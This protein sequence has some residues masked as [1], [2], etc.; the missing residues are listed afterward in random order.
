M[1]W[2]CCWTDHSNGCPRDDV[3]WKGN[4]EASVRQWYSEDHA[5]RVRRGYEQPK[6]AEDLSATTDRFLVICREEWARSAKC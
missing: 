4:D 5:A 3:E 6:S 1:V 2:T